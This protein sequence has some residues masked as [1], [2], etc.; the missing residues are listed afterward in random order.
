MIGCCSIRWGGEGG[1]TVDDIGVLPS[2]LLVCI[3]LEAAE[4]LMPLPLAENMTPLPLAEN[5]MPLP[6][7]L[8]LLVRGIGRVTRSANISHD[9]SKRWK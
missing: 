3:A 2:W 9:E 6:L 4:N 5:M 1:I 7:F 8:S